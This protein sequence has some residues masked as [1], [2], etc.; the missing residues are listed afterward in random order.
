M[1][2]VLTGEQPS[3]RMSCRPRAE[4][5]ESRV[6][7]SDIDPS[8]H[9]RGSGWPC[10]DGGA[11]RVGAS[12]HGTRRQRSE[13]SPGRNEGVPSGT[14]AA[15]TRV[16]QRESTVTRRSSGRQ[17]G[18]KA[19]VDPGSVRE[20]APGRQKCRWQRSSRVSCDLSRTCRGGP[21]RLRRCGRSAD[22]RRSRF[23]DEKPSGDASPA[24]ACTCASMSTGQS[25]SRSRLRGEAWTWA[26]TDDRTRPKGRGADDQP[27]TH[28]GAS[29][30]RVKPARDQAPASAGVPAR[31]D[32]LRADATGNATQ[33]RGTPRSRRP[34]MPSGS[35][36]A[37]AVRVD[38]P[39]GP[40]PMHAYPTSTARP[41]AWAR[42]G[43]GRGPV[44]A[45]GRVRDRDA[46][47]PVSV[48]CPM[49][50]LREPQAAMPKG[51]SGV[52]ERSEGT[53]ARRDSPIARWSAQRPQGTSEP[54]ADR[55][56]RWKEGQGEPKGVRLEVRKTSEGGNPRGAAGTKQAQQGSCPSRKA[57][58]L[59]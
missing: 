22:W 49:T 57:R 15:P 9:G 37:Q 48:Q 21:P 30:S 10:R 55:D 17:A 16:G 32:G 36:T 52:G 38:W 14:R 40:A 28:S 39:S 2:S 43:S 3:R 41:M 12:R 1:R 58:T 29:A 7:S 23:R 46:G 54:P 34:G 50:D 4:T 47:S 44:L 35:H 33:A 25:G 26:S 6:C 5:P 13:R 20:D 53:V 59:S 24:P 51:S 31:R 8:E 19:R 42:C 45:R 56:T 27:V 18:A 11:S